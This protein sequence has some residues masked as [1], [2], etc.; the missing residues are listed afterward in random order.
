MNYLA[1]AYL[2]FQQPK[3]LVGNMISDFV[4][5]K[6][7]FEFDKDVQEGIRLHRS[8][9]MF[10]DAHEVTAEAKKVFKPSVGLYAGA[11]MDVVYDHFLARDINELIE[12][13]WE[14]FARNTYAVL[15]QHEKI[16]PE[17]FALMLP[18][19]RSQNWLVNYRYKEGIKN[20]F[21]GLTRRAKYFDTS[22]KAYEAFEQHYELLEACYKL[23]F[24]AVKK[25]ALKQVE[26]YLK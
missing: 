3:I 11:F 6:K 23:F 22:E 7:K 2:S 15:Y 14:E 18:Y 25:F 19:M 16:L 26:E 13:D 1:H 21:K 8:I 10:T 5:G 17:R 20:S 12:K 9:D 4:K 24:P